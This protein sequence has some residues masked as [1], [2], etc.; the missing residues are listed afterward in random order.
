MVR[1]DDVIVSSAA[2]TK[3]LYTLLW[4][5]LPKHRS[6]KRHGI[7]NVAKIARDLGISDKAVY[8]WFARGNVSTRQAAKLTELDGSTLT[9]EMLIHFFPG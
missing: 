4:K 1:D 2:C 5:H 8:A 6:E 3:P 9:M 7:L